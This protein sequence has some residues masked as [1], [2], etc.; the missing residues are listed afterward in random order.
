VEFARE[1]YRVVCELLDLASEM[2]GDTLALKVP[3]LRHEDVEAMLSA[4]FPT[5]SAS[6]ALGA[7]TLLPFSDSDLSYL[8][9]STS[10]GSAVA[11][12]KRKALLDFLGLLEPFSRAN[13]SRR[14]LAG[15]GGVATVPHR[16]DASLSVIPSQSGEGFGPIVRAAVLYK[17]F[18]WSKPAPL[19]H[20][21][22]VN[23]MFDVFGGVIDAEQTDGFLTE[24]GHF[25]D[26]KH[27]M[28]V[29]HGLGQV[30]RT[31]NGSDELFS[32]DLW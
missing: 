14:E 4:R 16:F 2:E 31:A 1:R 12:A 28:I 21:D 20:H 25:F 17:N 19:R 30:I 29:A 22:I 24:S 18:V 26:R 5:W 15:A 27:A 23:E 11:A 8:S 10:V 7:M 13:R 9:H 6:D 32:E 3:R